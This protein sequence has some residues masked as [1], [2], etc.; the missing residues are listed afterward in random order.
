MSEPLQYS[1][2]WNEGYKRNM[3]VNQFWSGVVQWNLSYNIVSD[4]PDRKTV[5]AV[6]GIGAREYNGH[7]TGADTQYL[8]EDK[9]IDLYNILCI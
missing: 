4:L 1:I 8:H 7:L 5:G 2:H 9:Y 6:Y 3:E